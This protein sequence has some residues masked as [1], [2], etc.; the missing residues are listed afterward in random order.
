MFTRA[1]IA[2]LGCHRFAVLLNRVAVPVPLMV[3]TGTLEECRT[4]LRALTV[5]AGV[6]PRASDA[7]A[8]AMAQVA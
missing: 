2:P 8:P 3:Y 6:F 1:R 4:A 7:D 5:V